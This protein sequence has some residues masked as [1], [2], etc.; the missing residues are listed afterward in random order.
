VTVS[1]KSGFLRF[2]NTRKKN[3]KFGLLRHFVFLVK[4]GVAI[5]EAESEI[6]DMFL[7]LETRG[8]Q[9]LLGSKMEAKFRT[10]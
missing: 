2:K 9:V 4:K 10:F 7:H 8:L 6:T 3:T 1:I 5:S